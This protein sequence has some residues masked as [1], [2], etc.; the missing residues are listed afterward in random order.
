MCGH[1]TLPRCAYKNK[2]NPEICSPNIYKQHGKIR[3]IYLIKLSESTMNSEQLQEKIDD[4]EMKIAFQEHTIELLN[5]ALTD[6]QK[7]LE[8]IQRQMQFLL[9][10]MQGLTPSLLA[11]ESEETPP[12]HY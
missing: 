12:P 1:F 5:D 2:T 9:G 10:K 6:Q 8:A 7:Q 3:Q 11:S 4:L